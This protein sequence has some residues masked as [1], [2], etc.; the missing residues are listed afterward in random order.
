MP[1]RRQSKRRSDT[2]DNRHSSYPIKDQ[3]R[4]CPRAANDGFDPPLFALVTTLPVTCFPTDDVHPGSRYG[5]ADEKFYAIQR[6]A[7][8]SKTS[9]RRTSTRRPHGGR[10]ICL[11]SR[12]ETQ[13]SHWAERQG[14]RK[15]STSS[16]F[17]TNLRSPAIMSSSY[18]ENPCP[19]WCRTDENQSNST[20]PLS[21]TVMSSTSSNGVLNEPAAGSGTLDSFNAK[22]RKNGYDD[23]APQPT[24]APAVSASD[25]I[26]DDFVWTLAK[27]QESE[28]A[29]GGLGAAV[30][31]QHLSFDHSQMPRSSLLSRLPI[32]HPSGGQL[33]PPATVEEPF[34][35]PAALSLASEWLLKRPPFLNSG[36]EHVPDE[37]PVKSAS[38]LA[39][40]L[41]EERAAIDWDLAEPCHEGLQC[42]IH[43]SHFQNVLSGTSIPEQCNGHPKLHPDDAEYLSYDREL[44]IPSRNGLHSL[45]FPELL[46]ELPPYLTESTSSV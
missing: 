3:I 45:G 2:Q 31:Q 20:P 24:T 46:H 32:D 11:L 23:F 28:Q 27:D 8:E 43:F 1:R 39:R 10:S 40:S 6:N 25:F 33:E 36:G 35:P 34:I 42:H 21:G 12:D 18:M 19:D 14:L 41:A 22:L 5:V 17:H 9:T 7:L 38:M 30:P 44:D 4:P 15:E 16:A 37:I 29:A 13:R 26:T